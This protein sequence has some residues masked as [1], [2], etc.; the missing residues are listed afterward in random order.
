[1]VW[2]PRTPA[3]AKTA[4][5]TAAQWS[6]PSRLLALPVLEPMRGVR[7]NSP[8]TTTSVSSS[9]PRTSRSS[10]KA[11]TPRSIGGSSRPLSDLKLAECVSQVLHPAHVDLDDRHARLDQPP[12]QQE[13][14][15]VHVPAVAVAQPGVFA[16]QVEGAGDLAREQERVGPLALLGERVFALDGGRGDLVELSADLVE[17]RLAPI[18]PLDAEPVGQRQ[19]LEAEARAGSD[20][21]GSARGRASDRG[22]RRAG[23]ARRAGLPSGTSAAS[24]RWECRRRAAGSRR[25][26]TA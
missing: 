24:P 2:P 11:D 1:M 18:E 3:P 9:R 26:P 6:R 10:S 23:P 15:A 22:S 12:G 16:V 7:P 19:A 25:G 21:A 13:R 8:V 14:L 17:Q 5:K 20:P 4:E